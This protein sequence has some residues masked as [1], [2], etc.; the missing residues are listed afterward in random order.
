[1][2]VETIKNE[3]A[4][5]DLNKG[6]FRIIKDEPHIKELRDF[7]N[8]KLVDINTLTPALLI[9]LAGILLGKNDRDSDSVSSQ[10]FRN[11]WGISVDIQHWKV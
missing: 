5:Y 1:M 6:L 8:T 11:L 4:F 9:E 7:C 2:K 3:I 10:I